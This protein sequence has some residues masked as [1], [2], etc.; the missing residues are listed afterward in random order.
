MTQTAAYQVDN[1]RVPEDFRDL[2]DNSDWIIHKFVVAGSWSFF[3]VAV[4]AHIAVWLWRPWGM[5]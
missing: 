3:I 4:G 2:F 5:P 1:D